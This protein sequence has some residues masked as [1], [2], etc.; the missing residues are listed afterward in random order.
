MCSRRTVSVAGRLR[1]DEKTRVFPAAIE[2]LMRCLRG[3]GESG[4]C[5]EPMLFTG[6]FDDEFAGEYVEELCC[7]L[8]EMALLGGAGR[9]ALFD[10]AEGFGAMK[11]PAVAE[12]L[13]DGIWIRDTGPRVVLGV[14]NTDG[15][16]LAW[17]SGVERDSGNPLKNQSAAFVRKAASFSELERAAVIA[18]Y[19][20]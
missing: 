12:K 18:S 15:L 3:D 14:G 20:R 7:A 11:M 10:N 8:V 1:D 9:H 4:R 16:H 17:E 13:A 2:D 6:E 19:V 5:R